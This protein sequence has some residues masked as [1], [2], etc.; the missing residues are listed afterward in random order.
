MKNESNSNLLLVVSLVC[1]SGAT[2]L[3]TEIPGLLLQ[4]TSKIQSKNSIINKSIEKIDNILSNT[5]HYNFFTYT[6]GFENPFRK[7]GNN[8]TPAVATNNL[9]P[10]VNN[11]RPKLMLKGILMKNQSLAIIEDQSGQTY[12]RSAGETV[13]DQQI[14]SINSNKVVLR[15]RTGTYE[16]AVEEY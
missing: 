16:L 11:D 6:S 1:L 12:I 15:D 10:K 14:V 7:N 9:S 3:L 5:P 2:L 4:S 13:L 8:G